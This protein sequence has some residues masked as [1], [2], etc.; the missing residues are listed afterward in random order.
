METKTTERLPK[1]ADLQ[2]IPPV[3]E[4]ARRANHVLMAAMPLDLA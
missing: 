2:A 3:G 4:T 1:P